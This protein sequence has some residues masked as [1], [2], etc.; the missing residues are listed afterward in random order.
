MA[1][2]QPEELRIAV[3]SDKLKEIPSMI[4]SL[5]DLAHE[6]AKKM[7]LNGRVGVREV[8]LSSEG[9]DAYGSPL[10]FVDL[11]HVIDYADN[12][13]VPVQQAVD[14]IR[15]F[16]DGVKK[17]MFVE[18]AELRTR[19]GRFYDYSLSVPLGHDFGCIPLA[20]RLSGNFHDIKVQK[21][22]FGFGA[23]AELTNEEVDAIR[24]VMT[25]NGMKYSTSTT[26]W[27]P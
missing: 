24:E 12:N 11:A 27:L 9:R 17:G 22:E 2:R 7:G 6:N 26:S 15:L 23:R 25:S 8:F 3:P 5:S 14:D 10:G 18:G 21:N 13:G 4:S 1:E 16:R 20:G 19:S